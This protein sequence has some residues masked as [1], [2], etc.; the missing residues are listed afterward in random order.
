MVIVILT[1]LIEKYLL[2]LTMLSWNVEGEDLVLHVML[3]WVNMMKL[4]L[5]LML[6]IIYIVIAY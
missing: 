4:M 5:T 1:G 2:P 6:I 3:I